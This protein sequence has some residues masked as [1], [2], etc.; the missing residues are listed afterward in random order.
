MEAWMYAGFT[1]E[2]SGTAT[3]N[4]EYMEDWK[5]SIIVPLYKRGEEEKITN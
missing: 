5:E 1:E 3:K 4:M 2:V